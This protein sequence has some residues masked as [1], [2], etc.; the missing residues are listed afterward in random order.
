MRHTEYDIIYVCVYACTMELW[1][2]QYESS[3]KCF[4]QTGFLVVHLLLEKQSNSS[5]F[6]ILHPSISLFITLDKF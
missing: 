5:K 2:K 6:E 4:V 1:L 3:I